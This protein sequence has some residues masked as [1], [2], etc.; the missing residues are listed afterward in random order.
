MGVFWNGT[1]FQCCMTSS[2]IANVGE[3]KRTMTITFYCC[4]LCGIDCY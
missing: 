4:V 2:G 3:M 1:E